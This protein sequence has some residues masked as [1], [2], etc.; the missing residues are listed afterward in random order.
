[1]SHFFKSLDKLVKKKNL[2]K[3]KYLNKDVRIKK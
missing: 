3:Y 2:W 1:M